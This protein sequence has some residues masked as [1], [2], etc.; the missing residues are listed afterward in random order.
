[1]AGQRGGGE[2][3]ESDR[4]GYE[5]KG[6]EKRIWAGECMRTISGKSDMYH[7]NGVIDKKRRSAVSMVLKENDIQVVMTFQA[8]IHVFLTQLLSLEERFA[9]MFWMHDK[10]VL[11]DVRFLFYPDSK[12]V[13]AINV[14]SSTSRAIDF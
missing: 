6:M 12:C 2:H 11:M 8:S 4:G 7:M 5:G 10:L 3:L 13:S 14:R 9:F 1:M